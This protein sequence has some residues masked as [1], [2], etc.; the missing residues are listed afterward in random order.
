MNDGACLLCIPAISSFQLHMR[1]LNEL[2]S[3][4]ALQQGGQTVANF[5]Q[6]FSPFLTTLH[7]FLQTKAYSHWEYLH[8]GQQRGAREIRSHLVLPN[9]RAQ[10]CHHDG[11]SKTHNRPTVHVIQDYTVNAAKNS[12]HDIHD[13]KFFCQNFQPC[14]DF[15]TPP[16]AESHRQCTK[17][18]NFFTVLQN[19][20]AFDDAS[21]ICFI[22]LEDLQA[23]NHYHNYKEKAILTKILCIADHRLV[24]VHNQRML[25]I[26]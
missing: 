16:L 3:A 4:P 23:A 6:R 2:Q 15:S 11:I 5:S 22:C 21:Q 24:I 19:G 1:K 7:R 17:S 13:S 10:M 8:P 20:E 26:Q 25:D 18:V 14:H 12:F 9:L